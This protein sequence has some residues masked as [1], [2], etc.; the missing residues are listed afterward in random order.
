M[1][2]LVIEGGAARACYA[3][4]VAESLQKAGLV[5]DAIYGTSA[6]GAIGA[7]YAARQAH[8][9]CATWEHTPDR[10][11]LSY[12]RALLGRGHVLDFRRL[13]GEMY[14]NFFKM[15]VAALRASPYPVHVT[16]TD[17]DTAETLYPDLRAAEDPFLLLHATSAIPLV[18]ESPV[19]W[20]ERRVLDGG[21]TEPVPVAKAI[22][23]GRKDILVISNR[24]RGLRRPESPIVVA[25]M[26][27][28]FP[29]LRD[30]ARTRHARYNEALRLAEDPPPG[31]RVRLVRPSA[32]LGVSRLTRD[33]RLLRK[34]IDVG[35]RDGAQVAAQLG[36]AAPPAAPVLPP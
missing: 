33:L 35:R 22:E 13:Y 7:W 17:A 15:D 31:V 27:R 2:T 10:A 21:V 24:P 26:A 25:L 20:G 30:A 36:L 12:R 6:G 19:R 16:V 32:D 8:V 3:S 23:D 9:G 34:A 11:L 14:P 5:P 29:A 18:S 4:G 28:E 1:V